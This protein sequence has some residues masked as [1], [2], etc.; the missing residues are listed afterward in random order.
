MQK[1]IL[2]YQLSF[3]ILKKRQSQLN[4]VNKKQFELSTRQIYEIKNFQQYD[5]NTNHFMF[6][7]RPMT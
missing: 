7:Y 1:N 6:I 2:H 4:A 3:Q 5:L